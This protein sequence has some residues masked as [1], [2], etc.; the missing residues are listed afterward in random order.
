MRIKYEYKFVMRVTRVTS[1]LNPE[2]P[3]T[4]IS[5]CR[6]EEFHYGSG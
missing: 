5:V 4:E 3:L 1:G 6:M 2:L